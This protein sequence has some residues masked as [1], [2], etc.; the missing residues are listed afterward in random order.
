MSDNERRDIGAGVRID[1]RGKIALVTGSSSGL[2]LSIV[3]YMASAGAVVAVH[4][5]SEKEQADKVVSEI[6]SNGGRAMAFGGDISK[7]EEVVSLF[8]EIDKNLGSIDILVNNAG[9]D[10][11]RALCGED[12][13]EDWEKVIAVNLIG[14]YYCSREAIRR[15]KQKAKG[16]IINVT[17]AHEFIPWSGYSA[18][19]SSKA[20][21]SM[22]TK[23]IAQEVADFGIRVVS[24]APGAIRTPINKEVWNNPDSLKDLLKKIA[25]QRLGEPED[26]GKAAAFLASDL[27]GYVTGITLVVDGGMLLYPDFQHGG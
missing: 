19:C 7:L 17:S 3:K 1:L 21:L 23:T 6:V 18:Y 13:P 2:G 11:K 10:G 9:I 5:N 12:N 8:E 14:P 4:Y 26:I 22:L 24:L 20:G 25:M 16:V 27:A 15:M